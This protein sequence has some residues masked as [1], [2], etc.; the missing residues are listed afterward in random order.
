MA[1][2]KKT[3]R[4]KLADHPGLPKILRFD[5]KFPCG[6]ALLKMGASPGD[7]VVLAPGPEVEAVMKTTPRGKLLTLDEI[8]RRLAKD[9]NAA[10]CC[11]LTTG[12][13]V[14][15]VAHVAEE[16]RAEGKKSITPYWRTLKTD[17]FLNE[18]YPGGAEA[19][20][21]RLEEEGHEV[22]SKG[23][24]FFVKDWARRLAKPD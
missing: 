3:W 5:P 19:Q 4:Q 9:H 11:T 13:F 10:F 7:S 14:T 24:R 8:C 22:L 2:R 21:K 12:I 6:K 17:G 15:I 18:K 16:L 23:K 20:K 1:Y